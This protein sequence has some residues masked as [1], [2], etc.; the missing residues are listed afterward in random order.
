MFSNW[1][2]Q[3]W[4]EYFHNGGSCSQLQE[5]EGHE[6][7][8]KFK[9]FVMNP[10]LSPDTAGKVLQRRQGLGP[11]RRRPPYTMPPSTTRRTQPYTMPPS[12]TRRT[13]PYAQQHSTAHDEC[14]TMNNCQSCP[15]ER[16]SACLDILHKGLQGSPPRRVPSHLLS[17]TGRPM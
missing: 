12:T 4:Q 1:T 9:E 8:Q 17:R 10:N 2:N 5:E 16:R 6:C 15:D 3:K 11:D 13:Q 7:H 14:H